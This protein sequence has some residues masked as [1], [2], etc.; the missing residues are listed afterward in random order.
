MMETTTQSED[1]SIHSSSD[2]NSVP[3]PNP[4]VVEEA[5]AANKE[6]SSSSLDKPLEALTYVFVQESNFI[7]SVSVKLKGV[8][9]AHHVLIILM[10]PFNGMACVNPDHVTERF[11]ARG[12]RSTPAEADAKRQRRRK[13]KRKAVL[14]CFCTKRGVSDEV[15]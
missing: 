4:D 1:Q 12:Q 10:E 14:L 15:A 11:V 2:E 9:V 3:T 5:T 6:V 8:V 7:S 13:R